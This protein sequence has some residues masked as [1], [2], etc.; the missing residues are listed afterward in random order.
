MRYGGRGYRLRKPTKDALEFRLIGGTQNNLTQRDL[1]S[2]DA[3]FARV[4]M[5]NFADRFL[6]LRNDGSFRDLISNLRFSNPA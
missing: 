5:A 1:Y 4:G 3:E 6:T 2:A